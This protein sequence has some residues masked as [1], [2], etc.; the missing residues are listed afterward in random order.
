[1]FFPLCISLKINI[2]KELLKS[3]ALT[4]FQEIWTDKFRIFLAFLGGRGG[5]CIYFLKNP[6]FRSCDYLIHV[7]TIHCT[8]FSA[9]TLQ[10]IYIYRYIYSWEKYLSVVFEIPILQ[11][12]GQKRTNWIY[13]NLY[14]FLFKIWQ[15]N[16]RKPI[17][18]FSLNV[19][20]Y[21]Y[22]VLNE[23]TFVY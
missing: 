17:D 6:T 15:N 23:R 7:L 4:N 9:R 22:N 8:I 13:C 12:S 16:T 10:K 21:M 3:N 18:L 5:H 1:M 11:M 14:I 2:F 20:L 19:I